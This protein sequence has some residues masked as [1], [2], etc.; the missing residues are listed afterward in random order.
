VQPDP[1]PLAHLDRALAAVRALPGGPRWTDPARWHLTVAFLGEVDEPRVDRLVAAV[2]SA[3]DAGRAVRLRLRGAG[4]FPPRGAPRVLWAGVDGE[5][6]QW[7]R[8]ARAVGRA[9]RSAGVP[10]ERKPFQPHL[11]LG[12]WRPADPADRALATRLADY[13]G[14][15]FDVAEIVLMR[16][17]L[18]PDPRHERLLSWPLAADG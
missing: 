18:G 9:A 11:T 4:V 5:L 6:A 12:R 14:P 2:G 16:S 17:H 13:A 1:A 3:A 7:G 10:V 15:P 8:T